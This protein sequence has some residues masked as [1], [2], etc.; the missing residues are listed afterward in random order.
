MDPRVLLSL[1]AGAIS[2]GE[3]GLVYLALRRGPHIVTA[4]IAALS[5][6]LPVAVGVSTGDRIDAVMAFGLACA[7]IGA[8]VTSWSPA[9][10]GTRGNPFPGLVLAATAALG[11]GGFL[12]LMSAAS[13]ADAW[14]AV[15]GVR[16]GG[17]VT[18]FG[19][20][21]W[22]RSRRSAADGSTG[23]TTDVRSLVSTAGALV[24]LLAVSDVTADVA[25]AWATRNGP[26]SVV[27]VLAS[28]YPVST[29]AL[30]AV[31]LRERTRTVNLVGVVVACLGV[32]VLAATTT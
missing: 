2:V 9:A 5:A 1:A 24:A 23:L 12:V 29:I 6:G 18:A 27:A 15:G 16:L 13:G 30:A 26:L 8:A 21:V 31:L 4:P 11:A 14:W 3:L 28:L 32:A 22:S 17:S 10:P 25:Y 20:F 7:L 19:W